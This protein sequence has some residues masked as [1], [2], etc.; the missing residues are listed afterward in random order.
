MGGYPE[1]AYQYFLFLRSLN[2]ELFGI[3]S[4]GDAKNAKSWGLWLCA[5]AALRED[6][7]GNG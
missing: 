2:E 7:T 1:P 6:F 3:L 4:R 5:F